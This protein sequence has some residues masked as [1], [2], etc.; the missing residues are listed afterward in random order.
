[1]ESACCTSPLTKADGSTGA[2]RTGAAQTRKAVASARTD[3]ERRDGESMAANKAPMDAGRVAILALDALWC[4]TVSPVGFCP[5]SGVF[6]SLD[7]ESRT[8]EQIGGWCRR[9]AGCRSACRHRSETAARFL[10]ILPAEDGGDGGQAVADGQ[11]HRVAWS[12]FRIGD[13]WRRRLDPGAYPRDRLA[14]PL[15]HRAGA[16]GASPLHR[17]AA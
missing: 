2:A 14:H 5:F 15:R 6:R 12:A 3:R 16:R 17:R 1:M 10:R 7:N 8:A 9:F 11:A 4:R 13:L